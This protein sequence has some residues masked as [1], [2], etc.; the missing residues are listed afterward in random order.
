M[1]RYTTILLCDALN[2]G[3]NPL[4]HD[5]ATSRKTERKLI[6]TGE[7][8]IGRSVARGFVPTRSPRGEDFS[9]T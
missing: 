3:V 2:R 8:R 5:G 9:G 1:R 4:L 6:E 7:A